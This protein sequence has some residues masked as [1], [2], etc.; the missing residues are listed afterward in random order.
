MSAPTARSSHIWGRPRKPRCTPITWTPLLIAATSRR[1]NTGMREGRHHGDAA[2]TAD[3]RRQ[4]GRALWQAGFCLS[5]GRRC[6]PLSRRR[7]A[8]LSLHGR[9]RRTEPAP[10]LDQRVPDLSD[11]GAMH[12]RQGAAHHPL[13][14]RARRRGRAD[15]PRQKSASDACAPPDGR[16][17]VRHAEDADGRDALSDEATEERRHRNGAERARL[18]PHARD[19]Y[20][21]RQA[22]AGRD[23]GLRPRLGA[24]KSARADDLRT[25]TEARWGR[26]SKFRSVDLLNLHPHH[27]ARKLATNPALFYTAWTRSGPSAAQDPGA[28]D[29]ET[30]PCPCCG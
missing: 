8:D 20:R 14:T 25:P 11:Q 15:T 19:E 22:A 13:G 18:Q 23:A 27:R 3:V 24:T 29:Q 10:L 16:A 2:Q 9:G 26:F 6:L 28:P 21:R 12:E 30:P 17:S 5:A 4:V 1:G 7:E